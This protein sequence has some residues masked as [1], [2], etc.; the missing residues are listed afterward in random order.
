MSFGG[1]N[2]Y[3]VELRIGAWS[4][5]SVA[6]VNAQ[7]EA[8]I[9]HRAARGDLLVVSV[10]LEAADS[11]AE[12]ALSRVIERVPEG[13]TR[14]FEDVPDASID[15]ARFVPSAVRF[16]HYR[17]KLSLP[18]CTDRV[19]YLVAE[20]GAPVSARALKRLPVAEERSSRKQEQDADWVFPDSF[21]P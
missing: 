5:H 15:P 21:G 16:L 10:P 19:T 7:G 17:G 11:G 20:R 9:L 1:E 3:A 18:P 13:A 2:Y 12:A 6:G 4:I 14:Y 8:E